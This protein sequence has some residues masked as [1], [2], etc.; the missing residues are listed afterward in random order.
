MDPGA[1]WWSDPCV[2]GPRLKLW[3]AITPVK[4]CAL[5]DAGDVHQL[6]GL[7]QIDADLLADLVAIRG[8]KAQLAH[9][10]R[11]LMI[12]VEMLELAGDRLRRA[13]RDT[14]AELHGR[15]A[16]LLDVT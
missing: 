6:A 15:I 1:R 9:V 8:I 12:L 3:R 11:A 7:E 13:A 5:A 14:G 4:P 10:L 2:F 16:V